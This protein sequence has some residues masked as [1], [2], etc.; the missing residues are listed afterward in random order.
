MKRRK[1]RAL[2][3]RTMEAILPFIC[4]GKRKDCAA[5]IQSVVSRPC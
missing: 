1:M 2:V 3:T 4:S 5:A